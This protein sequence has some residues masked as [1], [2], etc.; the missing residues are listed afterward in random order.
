MSPMQRRVFFY[1]HD[2]INIPV[3]SLIES[4]FNETVLV[5]FY[6]C[7]LLIGNACW[8][9]LQLITRNHIYLDI[10]CESTFQ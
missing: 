6:N 10:L 3:A 2:F 5:S 4:V 1:S 7:L 8:I 9:S